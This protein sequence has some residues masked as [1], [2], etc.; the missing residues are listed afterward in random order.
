MRLAGGAF[1]GLVAKP[2]KGRGKPCRKGRRL[3]QSALK[4]V[5]YVWCEDGLC[6][7]PPLAASRRE[8]QTQGVVDPRALASIVNHTLFMKG[9]DRVQVDDLFSP[10]AMR[11]EL[12]DRAQPAPIVHC[13][14]AQF[15]KLGILPGRADPVLIAIADPL[16]GLAQGRALRLSRLYGQIDQRRDNRNAANEFSDSAPF[17]QSHC[18]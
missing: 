11:S 15:G 17:L 14:Y 10:P 3:F 1:N 9:Q 13:S 16:R 2:G 6:F 12:L 4:L 8:D 7:G 18:E 5:S